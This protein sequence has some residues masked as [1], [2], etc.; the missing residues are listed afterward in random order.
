MNANQVSLEDLKENIE[1]L[2]S[3]EVKYLKGGVILEDIVF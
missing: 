2:N 3:A 1:E